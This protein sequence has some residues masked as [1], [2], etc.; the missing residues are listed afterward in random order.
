MELPVY[1]LTISDDEKDNAEVNFVSLVET[2]A[3][4][5]NFLA[6]RNQQLFAIQDEDQRIVSGPAMVPDMPI[7]RSDENGQYYVV[8]DAAAIGKIAYR[9]FKKGYQAN[10]N[11]NHSPDALV[12]DSVFFESWLVDR[13]KGKAPMKGFE[14]LPDGTWFLTAKINSPDTWTKIKSGEYKGFSVEGLF[15]YTRVA[16]VDPERALLEQVKEILDQIED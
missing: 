3:I 15:E 13:E 12:V 5:R 14:D 6:F 8:F 7:F 1:T 16:K 9:F 11:T 4:E 2:P 10:I